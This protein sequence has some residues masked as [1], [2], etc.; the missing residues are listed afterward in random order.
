MP[1]LNL[2]TALHIYDPRTPGAVDEIIHLGDY[3][4][5]A[6]LRK[7]KE[8]ILEANGNIARLF[9]HA[10]RFLRAAKAVY[11]DWEA[12]NL[13]GMDFGKANK[14]AEQIIREIFGTRPASFIVGRS[15]HLFASAITPDGLMN[16]LDTIVGPCQTKYIIEGDP[17]TGK[18]TLLYKVATAAIER[19]HDVEFYHCPL[20]PEK[21]EHVVIIDLGIALTKSIE[22]HTYTPAPEDTIIDMNECLSPSITSKFL[23]IMA[24]DREI[25]ERLFNRAIRFIGEAK[26]EH[27]RMESFYTPAMDFDG[28]TELREQTLARILRYA[29]EVSPASSAAGD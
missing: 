14:K 17:G 6:Q 20:N 18:S 16:Y 11:D 22:P 25:F 26:T 4:D 13:K 28:I 10:Y 5:E 1:D 27:D 19:G 21:V 12:C 29:A 8:E 15:R 3:W 23:S 7:H 24:E 9:E 2:V